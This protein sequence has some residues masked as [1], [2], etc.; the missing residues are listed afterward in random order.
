M[1]KLDYNL[2]V[3]TGTMAKSGG[4][5]TVLCSATTTGSAVVTEKP[6]VRADLGFMQDLQDPMSRTVAWSYG[7]NDLKGFGSQVQLRRNLGRIFGLL[8]WR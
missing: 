8:V 1:T 4:V 6:A 5:S 3:V 7:S 2:S